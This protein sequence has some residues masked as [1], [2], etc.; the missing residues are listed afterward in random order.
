MATTP[1]DAQV[2]NGV[3]QS[4]LGGYQL[5]FGGVAAP[6]LYISAN[7]INAIV[8]IEVSGQDSV[9][10]TLVTPTGTF[11]LADLY[12]R[13]SEP[14]VFHDP[15]SGY[16]VAINQDGTLNSAANPAH[17]GQLV[18]IWAGVAGAAGVAP[19]LVDG[20][21]V[22]SSGSSFPGFILLPVS[23]ISGDDSGFDG[24]LEVV[25]AGVSPGKVFG[26]LQVNFRLPQSFPSGTSTTGSLAVSLQVGSAISAFVEIYVAP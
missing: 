12:I 24:S 6:L 11:P 5:L 9:S 18:S 4:N 16:A 23:I 17:V 10:V 3:V 25:Y 7:Q 26:L 13:P 8:P 15:V 2:V 22:P 19:N 1:L 20:T 14:E 21:I